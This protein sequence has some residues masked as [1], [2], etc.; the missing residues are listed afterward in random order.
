[1]DGSSLRIVSLDNE[2]FASPDGQLLSDD[3]YATLR[4]T[5]DQKSRLIRTSF[6]DFDNWK[7]VYQLNRGSETGNSIPNI[8]SYNLWINPNSGDSILIFQHRM[9]I[10][11][12]VDVVA[13]NLRTLEIEWKHENLTK[14]GNSNHQ[15]IFIHD[16]KAYFGGSLT[17]YCFDM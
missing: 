8:Q 13:Y 3:Y 17:F 16:N 5:D 6:D 10:P 1:E 9:A 15:Q 4:S 14:N 12:R 11:D 7:T 2:S